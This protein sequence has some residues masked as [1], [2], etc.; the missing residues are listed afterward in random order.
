MCDDH[1]RE[2]QNCEVVPVIFAEKID[3]NGHI[4]NTQHGLLSRKSEEDVKAVLQ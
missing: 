2:H 3:C 4:S 1:K